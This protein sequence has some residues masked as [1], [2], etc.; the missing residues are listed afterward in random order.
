M[1]S[2][3]NLEVYPH[4]SCRNNGKYLYSL[5]RLPMRFN[6]RRKISLLVVMSSSLSVLLFAVV[7]IIGIKRQAEED[8]KTYEIE[9]TEK[10]KKSLE[11]YVDLAYQSIAANYD[12]VESKEHIE[13]IYGHRLKNTVD[14][15]ISVLSARAKE[16]ENGEITLKKAQELAIKEIETMRYDE[17]TGYIWINDNTLPLPTMI[18]HPT[19]PALN[20][21]VLD[22]PKFNCAMGKGQNLFQAM[23]E[24]SQADGAGF[25]DYVWPKPTAEGLIPDVKKLSYVARFE[26]WDWV[27]GT[28][29]YLDDVKEDLIHTMLRDVASL[30][31]D[32]KMGYFW[33]NDGQLPYP[34]MIMHPTV[35]ELD[36]VVLDDPKYNCAKGT[37]ENFFQ[38]MAKKATTQD[39]GFVEYMWPKPGSDQDEPKLSFVRYFEPLDWVIG[40]GVYTD[41]ISAM[42]D[43]KRQEVNAQIRSFI[44]LILLAC[45]VLIGVGV[46]LATPLANSMTKAIRQVQEQLFLLAQGKPIE[47]IEVNRQDEISDMTHSLNRLVDGMSAYTRFATAIG[48]GD[49]DAAFTPLSEEDSLGNAL[50]QMRDELKQ[51]AVQESIRKWSNEGISIFS[52]LVSRYN[53]HLETLSIKWISQLIQYVKANQGSLFLIEQEGE[54]AYLKMTACYAYNRQKFLQKEIA[55]GEGLVG[56][57]ALE[58]EYIYLTEIPADYINITSGLGEA[59]PSTIIIV[60]LINNEELQGVFE[61]A[62]FHLF[63]EH[64]IEFLLKISE[65]MAATLA[66]VKANEATKRLLEESQD[67]AEEMKAQ[68]EELRQ[69]TEELQATQEMQNRKLEEIQGENESLRRKLAEYGAKTTS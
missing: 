6:I 7:V 53:H 50:V 43:Q 42:M 52:E 57:V 9:E 26:E 68:E 49:Q 31:Y 24:V 14:L 63:D 21:K 1:G 33:I 15:A 11:S 69:N 30:R 40:T 16:V 23:V 4:N 58:K 66:S 20:G 51:V 12:N 35:P 59:K 22:D 19:V 8:L 47:K 18:M 65:S 64:E 67:M 28:G 61:L 54:E 29:I 27:L 38:L 55:L 44:L 39:S 45:G 36:G 17:G 25:V 5:D 3:E 37:G 62:S 13:K 10:V 60:P 46:L 56:Q 48:K 34:T 32:N 41:N 2:G